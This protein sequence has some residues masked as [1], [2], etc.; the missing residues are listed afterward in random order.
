MKIYGKFGNY[1]KNNF[2]FFGV[3]QEKSLAFV[4]ES[5]MMHECICVRWKTSRGIYSY[6]FQ[7]IMDTYLWQ[8]ITLCEKQI[9][10]LRNFYVIFT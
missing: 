3:F 7:K 8:K 10:I 1:R 2:W 9:K 4:C 5:I 6:Y